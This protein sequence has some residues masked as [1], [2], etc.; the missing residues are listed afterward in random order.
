MKGDHN[1]FTEYAKSIED[2]SFFYRRDSHS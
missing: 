2:D 1:I